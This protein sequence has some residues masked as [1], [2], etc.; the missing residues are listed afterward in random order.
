VGHADTA[1]NGG[2]E[3]FHPD[4]VGEIE[5]GREVTTSFRLRDD[6]GYIQ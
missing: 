1:I 3:R 4:I 5:Y 2:G 6:E